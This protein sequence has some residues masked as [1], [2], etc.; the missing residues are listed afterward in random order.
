M[1]AKSL[2]LAG[3]LVLLLAALCSCGGGRCSDGCKPGVYSGTVESTCETS[4]YDL[5]VCP[6]CG[7]ETSKI[8][9]PLLE[10]TPSETWSTYIKPSCKSDGKEV[11]KCT[12]CD[13]ILE[14]RIL[15]SYAHNLAWTTETKATC[16]TKG[17]RIGKC[18]NYYYNAHNYK[19]YCDYSVEEEI[20]ALGHDWEE[21]SRVA[22]TCS[23]YGRE[24]GT[25]CDRCDVWQEGGG[26]IAKLPHTPYDV[27]AIAAT[28]T[29]SGKTAGT[30]CSVCH[31]VVSGQNT[32]SSLGHDFDVFTNKCTRCSTK[33]IETVLD[34]YNKVGEALGPDNNNSLQSAV[35][36]LDKCIDTTSSNYYFLTVKSNMKH[37]RLIGNASKEY[38]L[39]LHI[40][41]RTDAITL[42]L[43]NTTMVSIQGN[44]IIDCSSKVDLDVKFYGTKCAL[45]GATG[46]AGT[47]GSN[48]IGGTRK[49]GN[50]GNGG[51]GI[52]A[53]G[54]LTLT[55]MADSVIIKGGDG[56][57][58]GKGANAMACNGANGGNGG[59]GAQGIVASSIT[60]KIQSGYSKSN[61]SILGSQGGAGGAGGSGDGFLYGAGSAGKAGSAASAT[62][63]SVTYR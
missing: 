14:E 18:T 19:Y 10:H 17:K 3:M 30:S 59:N 4:G 1:K 9:L 41:D 56:G 34:S 12:K 46:K 42:E 5:Y 36:E 37:L 20:D 55:I 25:Q 57:N 13:K 48:S 21:C 44:S 43:V 15:D 61:L 47:N 40:Q 51:N 11:I 28:C 49:G 23:S 33:Q 39:R 6:E 16:T 58:G 54:E 50:G 22:P 8:G 26:Q 52:K 24:E 45:Y 32:V 29:A 38:R 63:V 60:V 53:G 35:V 2:F 7:Y 31:S 62:N 27:S